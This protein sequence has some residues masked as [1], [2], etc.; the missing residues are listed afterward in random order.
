[1]QRK[2]TYMNANIIL[3]EGFFDKLFKY[4]KLD[5]DKKA[6]IKLDKRIGKKLKNLNNSVSELEKAASSWAGTDIK[7]DKFELKDFK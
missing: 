7:L 6:S 3:S 4:F 5:K 2:K 1:V